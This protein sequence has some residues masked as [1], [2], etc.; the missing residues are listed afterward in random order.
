MEGLLPSRS[1]ASKGT[2]IEGF[3]KAWRVKAGGWKLSFLVGTTTFL[4]FLVLISL[5]IRTVQDESCCIENRDSKGN[6][7]CCW[8]ERVDPAKRNASGSVEVKNGLG[9]TVMINTYKRKDNL[10][11][12]LRH[13]GTCKEVERIRVVWG[14]DSSPPDPMGFPEFYL[15]DVQVEFVVAERDSLNERFRIR[16]PL[17]T[18]AVFSVDDD[19]YVPC[20]GL[21]KGFDAWK[22][23]PWQIVG[24]FPRL[25]GWET[26]DGGCRLRYK[27]KLETV[28]FEGR[29]SILL[30]KAAFLHV[31]YFDMYTNRMDERIRRYVDSVN[32][33]EDVAMQLMVSNWTGSPPRWVQSFGILDFGQGGGISSARHHMASRSACLDDLVSYYD[34]VPL[35]VRNLG[36]AHPDFLPMMLTPL[37]DLF[38]SL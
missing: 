32:N 13:Y 28:W 11:L 12:S 36:F 18:S 8:M 21:S 38:F 25:H 19:V 27:T 23:E 14:E 31:D 15:G 29:Y 7:V 17:N 2:W 20:T 6:A 1:E 35:H 9:F 37:S 24:Y 16:S 26:R 4:F 3:R 34:G 33:C 22:R 30:T 10:L 5:R